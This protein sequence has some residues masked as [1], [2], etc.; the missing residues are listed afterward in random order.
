VKVV[1][2]KQKTKK[3]Y[4][5]LIMLLAWLPF[6]AVV[7]FFVWLRYYSIAYNPIWITTKYRKYRGYI[8]AQSRFESADY[9]SRLYKEQNNA[10]GMRQAYNRRTTSLGEREGYAD[11]RNVGDSLKDYIEWLEFNKCSM[12]LGS[13]SAYIGFLHEK[14]YFELFV[15]SYYERVKKYY[16]GE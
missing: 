3:V 4:D 9:T 8:I 10:F 14:K 16:D 1:Y 15:L 2:V 5:G 11:Y 12:D 6:A 13:L 7:F